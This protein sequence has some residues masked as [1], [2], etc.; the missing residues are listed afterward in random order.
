MTRSKGSAADLT[1]QAKALGQPGDRRA[2][3][4]RAP[5]ARDERQLIRADLQRL[6]R[7]PALRLVG[8]DPGMRH[9]VLVEELADHR[10]IR[11]AKMPEK[12]NA[13]EAGPFQHDPARLERFEQ[14]VAE[15]G[16]LLDH[17][18]QLGLANAVG[19]AGSPG[20]GRDGG[21]AVGQQRDVSG[22]FARAMDDDRL[23]LGVRFVH[24]RDPAR[25][26]DVKGQP[27]LPGLEDGLAIFERAYLRQSG[28]CFRLRP[29]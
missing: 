25:L 17:P 6:Q 8:V 2:W 24:D 3:R 13:D 14:F 18:S 22:E 28:Q 16:N 29:R 5:V 19:P 20:I 12:A 4:T 26:D 27:A 7:G 21:R 1:L 10:H 23:R 11:I 9:L 15:V